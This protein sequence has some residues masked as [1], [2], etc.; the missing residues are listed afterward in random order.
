LQNT[1]IGLMAVGLYSAG[2]STR[3]FAYSQ[4][5]R[6]GRYGWGQK[7]DV[8]LKRLLQKKM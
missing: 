7:C 2:Y 4:R 3:A 6:M 5:S 8:N 1:V